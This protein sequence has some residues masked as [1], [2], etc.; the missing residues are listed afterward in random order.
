MSYQLKIKWDIFTQLITKL[1]HYYLHY[2]INNVLAVRVATWPS[3]HIYTCTIT[4]YYTVHFV[5]SRSIV[6][7]FLIIF[8][9]YYPVLPL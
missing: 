2:A 1:C 8:T 5:L 4:P 6:E 3:G 9:L 7:L